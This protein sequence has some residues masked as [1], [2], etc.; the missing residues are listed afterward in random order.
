MGAVAGRALMILTQCPACRA[1]FQI[2]SEALEACGGAVRCGQC[3]AVFQAD[4]YSLD[5]AAIAHPRKPRSRVWPLAVAAV[6][7]AVALGAQ[8]LY[9]ARAPLARTVLTR[10]VIRALCRAVPC[11]LP[12]PAALGRWHLLAPRV[13]LSDG[14]LLRIRARLINTAAF[15]QSLPLLGV[16]LRSARGRIIARARFP[17]HVFLRHPRPALGPGASAAVR[18]SLHAPARAAGWRLSLLATAR[19]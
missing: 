6:L 7:L 3:G 1:L 15:R 14:G 17:A 13:T 18:L 5:S 10:P 16:T 19:R 12:H 9:A 11:G 2:D 8:G 4:I